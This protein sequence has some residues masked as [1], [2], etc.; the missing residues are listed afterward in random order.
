M[1]AALV[2]SGKKLSAEAHRAMAEGKIRAPAHRPSQP[3]KVEQALQSIKLWIAEL[4]RDEIRLFLKDHYPSRVPAQVLRA[5]M[6]RVE[7]EDAVLSSHTA[8]ILT[9]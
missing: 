5:D 2:A 6:Q 7:Q 8:A 4:V 3:E 1:V 9:P